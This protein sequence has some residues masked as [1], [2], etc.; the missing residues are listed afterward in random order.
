MTENLYIRTYN[1]GLAAKQYGTG[2]GGFA[3]VVII[4]TPDKKSRSFFEIK[5]FHDFSVK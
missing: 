3:P 2:S 1:L 4:V 5:V